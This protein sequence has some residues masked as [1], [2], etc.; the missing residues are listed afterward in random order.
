MKT[1]VRDTSIESF[2]RIKAD[3]TAASQSAKI[4]KF[5][6]RRKRQKFTRRE[7]ADYTGMEITAAGRCV[8]E[9]LAKKLIVE[10]IKK[11]VAA[12]GR[13]VYVVHAKG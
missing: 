7:L 4:L 5:I 9:L 8:N 11:V 3:G 2:R 6:N 1:S 10:P 13:K 12:T